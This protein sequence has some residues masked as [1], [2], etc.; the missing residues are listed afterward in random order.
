MHDLVVARGYKLDLTKTRKVPSETTW[1]TACFLSFLPLTFP[2]YGLRVVQ[3]L[4]IYL[5]FL[6]AFST[7]LYTYIG[8]AT[9]DFFQFTLFHVLKIRNFLSGVDP[10]C[11]NREDIIISIKFTCTVISFHFISFVKND[12]WHEMKWKNL[13]LNKYK[14]YVWIVQSSTGEWIQTKKS[15][16][17]TLWKLLDYLFLACSWISGLWETLTIYCVIVSFC[18][19]HAAAANGEHTVGDNITLR[20]RFRTT[21][22][23]RSKICT[24]F[25]VELN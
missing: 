8:N 25:Y 24:L 5:S 9:I 22:V 3:A 2:V 1:S 19:Q 7:F 11:C 15:T 17:V 10:G 13:L 6:Y 18:A 12:E 4:F 21:I 23:L 20:L 14:S 16:W